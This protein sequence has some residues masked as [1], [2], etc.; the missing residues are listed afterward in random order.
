M[1]I[2]LPGV[3]LSCLAG[4]VGVLSIALPSILDRHARRQEARDV[5]RH[6]IRSSLG[7][8]QQ[9]S[10]VAGQMLTTGVPIPE[11]PSKLESA[12][13][14]VI[15][16]AGAEMDYLGI[17]PQL[18]AKK[19]LA[20]IGLIEIQTN[21]AVAANATPLV[22]APLGPLATVSTIAAPIGPAP[23]ADNGTR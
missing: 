14:Y 1:V 17:D 3:A 12:V 9:S 22:P 21:Q 18:V 11:V 5:V 8:L 20:Q 15:E 19:I 4:F 7:A 13:R 6:A 10:S 16:H 2:D 23:R